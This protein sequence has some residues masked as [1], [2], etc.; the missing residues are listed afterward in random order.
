MNA[1]TRFDHH[2]HL[3]YST[4]VTRNLPSLSEKH[5]AFDRFVIL[6]PPLRGLEMTLQDQH[7]IQK[8]IKKQWSLGSSSGVDFY[9]RDQSLLD[10]HLLIERFDEGLM[11]TCNP[12]CWGFLVNLEPMQTAIIEHGDR[13]IVGRFELVFVEAS[14]EPA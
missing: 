2:P 10:I 7:P 1:Q 13:V 12:R 14:T 5:S 9:I 8:P 11:L 3:A 4:P 6:S